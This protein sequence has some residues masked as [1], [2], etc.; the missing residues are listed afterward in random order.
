MLVTAHQVELRLQP[1]VEGPA[2]VRQALNLLLQHIT[3]V[4]RVRL[5]IHMPHAH[6][7]PVTWLPGHRGQGRQI[8]TGHKIRAVGL[9]AHAT[10]GK[11]GEPGALFG[12][13]LEATNR[14]RLGFRRTV[15][16]DKLRKHVLDPVLIDDALGFCWQHYSSL[17]A[18]GKTVR[19]GLNRLF[20][21]KKKVSFPIGMQSPCQSCQRC[22][23]TSPCA[24]SCCLYGKNLFPVGI[25]PMIR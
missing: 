7:S 1:G 20:I 18:K 3:A 14:H 9:H 8:A 11:T 6:H 22:V 13:G 4:V 24:F 17:L 12:D 5:A 10:N 19:V 23:K 25:W 15:N 2:L 16:I 21:P